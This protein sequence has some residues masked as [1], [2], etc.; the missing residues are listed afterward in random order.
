MKLDV[1]DPLWKHIYTNL[2]VQSTVQEQRN[3]DKWLTS[4][5]I[6][7]FRGVDNRVEYVILPEDEEL[8][9]FLLKYV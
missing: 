4:Y 7:I 8:T 9:I 1:G 5:G 3:W 6:Q 2:C